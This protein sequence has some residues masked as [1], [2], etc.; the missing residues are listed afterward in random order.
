MGRVRGNKTAEKE[1]KPSGKEKRERG[2]VFSADD[3]E[4]LLEIV[5]RY[6]I[7]LSKDSDISTRKQKN[8]VWKSIA[9]AYNSDRINVNIVFIC[10]LFSF[11]SS[12]AIFDDPIYFLCF[13]YYSRALSIRFVTNWMR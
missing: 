8:D 7:V 2:P 6:P 11:P 9:D 3:V 4:H 12:F 1:N 13:V 5:F 10:F